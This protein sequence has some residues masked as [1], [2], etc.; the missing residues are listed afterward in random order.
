[1]HDA[2]PELPAPDRPPARL[3]R[4][5]ETLQDV[6]LSPHLL[7]RFVRWWRHYGLAKALVLTL[8][9]VGP[10]L[11][12]QILPKA[13]SSL[14]T[15]LAEGAG[16]RLE[17]EDWSLSLSEFSATAHGVMLKTGGRYGEP[18]VLKAEAVE[19]DASLRQ[20]LGDGFGRLWRRIANAGR[21]AV[22]SRT[23]PLA[24]RPVGRAIR[25]E[26]GELYLERLISG[27]GNWQDVVVRTSGPGAAEDAGVG[28]YFIP[29]V[30]LRDFKITFVEHL[31]ADPGAGMEQTLTSTLHI[32][33]ATIA[34]RD[35][36]GPEDPRED[37][38]DF[39]LDGRLADGRLS[40]AGRF[41]L[42][43]PSFAI[44]IA[45]NNVG[46]ATLGVLLPDAAIVPSA[47]SIT[48]RVRVA[49]RN[50][51]LRECAINVRFQNVQYRPNPRAPFRVPP[52]PEFG[53]QVERIDLTRPVDTPCTGDWSDP[54]FRPYDA[55]YTR[56][57]ARALAD[58]PPIVAA[59]AAFDER[60]FAEG[61]SG[62]AAEEE[63][64][65]TL[66]AVS[67][68]VRLQIG[69]QTGNAVSRGLKSFGRGVGRLFGRE[70]K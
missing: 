46:A 27:H 16:L 65:R 56:M 41:N 1:M 19:I 53:P 13:T 45:M 40:I 39:S 32:D 61:L 63:L 28:A 60:R 35:F 34:V 15:T 42:W 14:V 31:P 25:V 4:A 51:T 67:Q 62:Q 8:A 49:V 69:E 3:E 43:A 68:Q 20:N 37:P 52:P 29:D 11:R 64:S 36:V 6:G 18:F 17:V 5:L 30:E 21:W 59:A 58:A 54:K 22:G 12:F 48:G 55:V 23:Y 44:D 26:G 9:V 70:P 33:E 10:L 50:E 38:S 2:P 24:P 47:G 7:E 57:H 66:A